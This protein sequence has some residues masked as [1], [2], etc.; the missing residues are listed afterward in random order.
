MDRFMRLVFVLLFAG[1]V[2]SCN[3][4]APNTTVS[5]TPSST[6]VSPSEAASEGPVTDIP[7][8]MS[9]LMEWEMRPQGANAAPQA[10]MSSSQIY[11]NS[12]LAQANFM[13]WWDY[14]LQVPQDIREPSAIYEAGIIVCASRARGAGATSIEAVLN[15]EMGYTP[16]GASAIT[17]AA[18]ASLCPQRD[19]GY[20][21]YFD[22]NVTNFAYGVKDKI[23]F[24]RQPFEYEFGFFMKEVC[25]AMGTSTI[26]GTGIFDHINSLVVDNHFT[27][28]GGSIDQV[29][30]RIMINE[31]VK[32]GCSGFTTQLPPVIQMAS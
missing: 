9:A 32:A 21:T 15:K 2:A 19:L 4:A 14:E 29:V 27:V 11:D 30:I 1:L 3:E 26:G 12:Q 8:D 5:K 16:S 18:L 20:R 10:P 7:S 23:T 13:A 24:N 25:A 22:R 31:S 28:L 17:R 6:A